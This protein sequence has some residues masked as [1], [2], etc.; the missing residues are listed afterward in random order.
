MDKNRFN[1]DVRPRVVAIPVG[2]QSIA[3]D[4]LDLDAWA[5]DH[6]RRNRRPAAQSE[7]RTSWDCNKPPGLTLRGKA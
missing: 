7:G 3:F 2:T 1:R 5:D 4:R 6:K